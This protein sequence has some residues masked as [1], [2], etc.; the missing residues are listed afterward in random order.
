MNID[1]LKD[2]WDQDEPKGMH[3]PLTT[4]MLG[5]STSLIG[6]IRRNMKAEFIALLICYVLIVL[7]LFDGAR[8]SFFYNITI[9]LLFSLVVL[10]CFYYF[11]FYVLYKSI[12]RYDLS[13]RESIRKITYELE[14]NSEIYKTYS[15]SAMPL[16]ILVSITL[17][18]SKIKFEHIGNILAADGSISLGTMLGILAIILL[19]F[20]ITYLFIN[21]HVRL[22][23][24]K[25][26][27]ELKQVMDDLGGDA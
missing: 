18:C 27:S 26:L 5:K 9:I 12:G 2:A 1:E 11:R 13:M 17:I 22:N 16:S 20:G 25:H 7:V 15:V 24:S 23:Y 6:K 10:N 19:S 21:M 14:L 4:A 8:S 3:L